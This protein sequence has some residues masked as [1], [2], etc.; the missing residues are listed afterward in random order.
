M[1]EISPRCVDRL[2]GYVQQ[3]LDRQG[4]TH[5][6]PG[7]VDDDE[8]S[9]SIVMDDFHRFSGDGGF[10]SVYDIP[11]PRVQPC[12]TFEVKTSNSIRSPFRIIV[13]GLA[14]S[15]LIVVTPDSRAY[16]WTGTRM[17]FVSAPWSKIRM[18]YIVVYRS[19]PEFC[20]HDL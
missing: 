2:Q 3:G 16:L 20:G 5:N 18:T 6:A 17:S 7:F 8:L 1:T 10:V 4:T 11:M 9:F 15:P 13:S 14:I 12:E 19:V